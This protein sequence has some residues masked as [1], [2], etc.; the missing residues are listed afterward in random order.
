MI[1]QPNEG[2]TE[3]QAFQILC[4]Q[5]LMADEH[6]AFAKRERSVLEKRV[7]SGLSGVA[8][9]YNSEGKWGLVFAISSGVASIGSGLL[10][11]IGSL[12]KPTAMQAFKG[13]AKAVGGVSSVLDSSG[14][15]TRTFQEG[16]KSTAQG[17]VDMARDHM[18]WAGKE[19]DDAAQYAGLLLNL[20]QKVSESAKE[21]F[22]GR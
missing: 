1:I 10:P 16:S 12:V 8:D 9:I 7:E 15:V 13:I 14:N 20:A 3:Y 2:Y 21:A 11:G 22:L 4:E 6:K 5:M 17:Q 18:G 19:A